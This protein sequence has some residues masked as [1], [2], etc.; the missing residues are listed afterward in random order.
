M[1][2]VEPQA[3]MRG[4]AFTRPTGR[5]R[6]IFTSDRYDAIFVADYLPWGA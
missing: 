4:A 1:T 3:D 5:M 2:R 6:E